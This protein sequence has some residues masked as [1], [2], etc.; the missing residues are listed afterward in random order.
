MLTTLRRHLNSWVAKIFFMLLVAT[1]VLWGVGDVITNIGASDTS[2]ATVGGQKIEPAAV[3]A[4]YQRQ[5]A[6]LTQ[7]LGGTAEPTADMRKGVAAQALQQIITQTAMDQAVQKLGLAAPDDAVRQAVFDIP[8]LRNASGQ[9]DRAQFQALLS[10]NNMTEAQFLD[11]IRADLEQRQL[12]EAARAGVVS[13]DI[14]TREVY[15]FQHELRLADAVD[16][17]FSAAPAP[18]PPTEAQLTRWWE[19]HPDLYSSP[20][21]RHIKAVVLSPQTVTK[22][23]SVT[24]DDLKAEYA[25]HQGDT[26]QAEKRS[27]QVLLAP[28]QATADALAKMWSA[29]ADWASMQKQPNATA[30]ELDD[31][32]AAEFPAPELAAA[33]F[34]AAV[35][36][37]APPVHSALGWHV[38]KVTKITPGSTTTLDQM[39]DQL[40][41]EV[42][43]RKAAD[44][45]DENAGKIEDA[46]AGGTALDGLP[47]NLGLGAVTGTLDAQGNTPDGTPAPIPGSAALRSALIGAAFKAKIGDPAQLIDVPLEQGAGDAY[48][49]LTVDSITPPAVKPLSA[50]AE[51][52]RADWTHD[53]IRHTQEEKAA[54]I[55]TALK[56]GKKME[57]AAAGL[58]VR[59][60]PPVGRSA[61]TPGVADQLVGPLFSL[62]IGEP[63]M[64]ETPDGFVVALLVSVQDPDPKGDPTGYGQLR[65]GLT[66]ALGDD[67]QTVLTTAL[68][69]RANPKVNP[70]ALDTIAQSN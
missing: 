19:N 67:V 47:G 45:I 8:G 37:V 16:L 15:A 41:A 40:R 64:V 51:A 38:F 49:A 35:G 65:D 28:D 6:Q 31:A 55:L 29:G 53:A 3:Q 5:L 60:L 18:P 52:V 2:V 69:E 13:P 17:P 21:Y 50:V 4:L 25:Q 44:I 63:T 59:Q 20:E 54:A 42:I 43:A 27:V 68:R 48:F 66:K 34:K 1:F 46:L 7:T 14:L 26:S 39:R 23:I 30:V 70:A 24:D 9:F 32:T 62:K 22:D 10:N 36:T 33:V 12:I 11:L 57:D 58:T 61:A 56:D